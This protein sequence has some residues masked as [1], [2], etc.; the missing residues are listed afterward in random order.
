M[1]NCSTLVT[2]EFGLDHTDRPARFD[3]MLGNSESEPWIAHVVPRN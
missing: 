2:V 3:V 1:M